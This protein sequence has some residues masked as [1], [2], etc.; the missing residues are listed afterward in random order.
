MPSK[1]TMQ[2]AVNAWSQ[3]ETEWPLM[4]WEKYLFS[5]NIIECL[6]DAIADANKNVKDRLAMTDI[7]ND[8]K[9]EPESYDDQKI[10]SFFRVMMIRKKVQ[11]NHNE[12]YE[13]IDG[14]DDENECE[15][16]KRRRDNAKPNIYIYIMHILYITLPNPLIFLLATKRT[17][18]SLATPAGQRSSSTESTRNG[19]STPFS[20]PPS[21]FT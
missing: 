15:A 6:V 16:R 18:G 1:Q 7:Q 11:K 19:T 10:Y 4:K 13:D 14:I 8:A 2:M 12:N 5:F 3:N 21:P 9:L 17:I 20:T